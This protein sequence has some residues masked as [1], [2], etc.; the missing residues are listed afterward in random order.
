MHQ[1][2]PGIWP[3][4]EGWGPNEVGPRRVGGQNFALFLPF[5]TTVSLFLSLGVFS[6]N[7]GGVLMRRCPE[8]CTFG[9]RPGLVGLPGFH[10]TSR[11]V[12][13][14][15]KA[16]CLDVVALSTPQQSKSNHAH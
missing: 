13:G 10:T 9:V 14:Q 4:T 5:L 11:E 7:C 12:G 16:D 8:I 2:L 3:R 6:W 15:I 1:E